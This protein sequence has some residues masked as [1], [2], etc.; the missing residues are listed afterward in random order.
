RMFDGT[1]AHGYFDIRVERSD[2]QWLMD[3][4]KPTSTAVVEL[5]LKSLEGYFVKIARSGRVDFPR[6]RRVP[7]GPSQWLTVRA[8]GGYGSPRVLVHE[9]HEPSPARAAESRRPESRRSF[10]VFAAPFEPVRALF[11]ELAGRWTWFG[12]QFPE[13]LGREWSE[14]FR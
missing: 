10:D 8:E 11:T 1:N 5:G 2:R 4:G 12:W 14:S 6:D 9:R 3:V 13:V 7:D